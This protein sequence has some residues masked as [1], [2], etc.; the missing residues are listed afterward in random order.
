MSGTP[1][2]TPSTGD[3]A[4]CFPIRSPPA[5]TTVRVLHLRT[6]VPRRTPSRSGSRLTA[7]D[8]ETAAATVDD[9][10]ALTR[11]PV[12]DAV[13]ASVQAGTLMALLSGEPYERITEDQSWARLI[14][15]PA[16]LVPM[17]R[18]WRVLAQ[19]AR[20]RGEGM[21]CWMAV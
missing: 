5:S 15:G 19:T 17:L 18:D 21:Y 1:P 9:G 14:S 13:E 3:H 6:S 10:P 16:H 8:D 2:R 20:R 4:P 12:L 7:P 11:A